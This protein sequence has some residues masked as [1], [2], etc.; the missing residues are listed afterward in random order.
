MAT[1]SEVGEGGAAN[2]FGRRHFGKGSIKLAL[3]EELNPVCGTGIDS[4]LQGYLLLW[5]HRIHNAFVG[6]LQVG[7]P[8]A[9]HG[10][11]FG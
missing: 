8:R 11:S 6:D 4:F 9:Q 2:Y 1:K 10:F 5:I 7:R 3:V